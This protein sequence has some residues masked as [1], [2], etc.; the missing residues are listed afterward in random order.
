MCIHFSHYSI[1]LPPDPIH[2][3]LSLWLYISFLLSPYLT[4]VSFFGLI[5]PIKPPTTISLKK[6][7]S[8]IPPQTLPDLLSYFSTSNF[9]ADF[10]CLNII[11][12][13]FLLQSTIFVESAYCSWAPL[14]LQSG[15]VRNGL[16]LH[17]YWF[18][19]IKSTLW[20]LYGHH[21]NLIACLLY[22]KYFS[23]KPNCKYCKYFDS[24][25]DLLLLRSRHWHTL[26]VLNNQNAIL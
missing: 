12:L 1:P 4:L 10:L 16:D 20:D 24:H 11:R 6:Y 21:L 26:F 23:R 8:F 13:S 22:C 18:F 17:S 9:A 25:F 3:Y 15:F 14:T 5:R 7:C 19:L 2:L